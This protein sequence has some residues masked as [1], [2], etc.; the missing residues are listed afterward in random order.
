MLVD[1]Y[2]L[3]RPL[4][5][6]LDAERSHS[7]AVKA[8]VAYGAVPGRIRPR[9]GQPRQLM[10]LS[11]ANAVGLAAG[12]DKDCVAVRGLARLGFGHIELGAVT[13]RHQPGNAR[14][15]LHR[16][17][18]HEGLINSMG[19]NNRGA[20]AAARKLMRL[21]K[22][23][24]L[25]DTVIGVNIGANHDTPI[26]SATED[27]LA[28]MD[29]LHEA[30]DYFSINLSSPNTPG[31]RRLQFG[32]RLNALLGA[33]KSHQAKLA[34]RVGRPLPLVLK[35]A[36]DL[37]ES[38]VAAISATCLAHEVDGIIAGNT[39]LTR[40]MPRQL[41]QGG[42]SGRP[43]APLAR[44]LVQ[45]FQANLQGRIPIIGCGGVFSAADAQEML[46]LGADLV[47]VYTGLV[48]QGPGLV[49]KLAG[50]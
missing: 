32:E 13:P 10:G 44:R 20:E 49:R 6:R 47:Q 19:F 12:L 22:S 27:Y 26:E 30:V 31:L 34:Q 28:C 46:D 39:T 21:R 25:P 2:R 37:D 11:F 43:L 14:P 5:F 9:N 18:A 36:P 3:I 45:R 35:L 42:L 23:G 17:P 48:F 29:A 50:L 8:L 15:R 24:R 16:A 41:P 4:L 40:P 38:S 1:L 33:L 7:L